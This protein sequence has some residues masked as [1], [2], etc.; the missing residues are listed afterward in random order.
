MDQKRPLCPN[1]KI[2]KS[3]EPEITRYPS[4]KPAGTL[5]VFPLNTFSENTHFRLIFE[6][7]FPQKSLFPEIRNVICN[8]K[9]GFMHFSPSTKK[10]RFKTDLKTVF[11]DWK[12]WPET[13]WAKPDRPWC[14]TTLN[15]SKL[16]PTW[17]YKCN[18]NRF[19]WIWRTSHFP[20]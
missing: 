19:F 9:T 16:Y 7:F 2:T 20:L 18:F 8:F 4:S 1:P 3:S 11:L 13:P 10:F 17:P 14:Q 12:L 15:P 6:T 5:W